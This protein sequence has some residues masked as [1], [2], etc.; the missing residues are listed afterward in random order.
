M[1]TRA[2]G[3]TFGSFRVFLLVGGGALSGCTP[4]PIL[5]SPD[6]SGPETVDTVEELPDASQ[7]PVDHESEPGDLIIDPGAPYFSGAGFWASSSWWESTATGGY[8]GPSYLV[9]P[10]IEGS[11]P[12][13]YWWQEARPACRSV[14]AWWT[15]GSN[16]SIRATYL[17]VDE[18]GRELARRVVNQ[19]SGGGGWQPLFDVDVPAG[20]VRVLLSRWDEPGRYTVADA[21]RI[22]SC[23]GDPVEP[24]PEP[25]PEPDPEVEPWIDFVSPAAGAT[26]DN[27]VTFRMEGEGIA[28][29]RLSSDGWE[30]ASWD[31]EREGWEVTY[32][33]SETDRPR[34]IRAEA[35]SAT[36]ERVAR[37]ERTITPVGATSGLEDVP[38][39]YQYDNYYEPSATCGLT[40]TAMV[41][42]YWT[43]R[44]LVPD[45][46][47]ERYGKAQGQS[48]SGISALLGWY[49]LYTEWTTNGSRADL[50]YWLDEGHP[51]IVHGNWTGAGHIAVL[52]GYDDSDWIV[53]D[54]AGDWE[55]CYGCG[56]GEA[57]RYAR[58]GSWDSRLSWDGDIW[59]SVAGTRPL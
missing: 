12:A 29:I 9:A 1:V 53:H 32:S 41:L 11:D 34:N 46:L 27:P 7:V 15:D 3:G 35:F 21:I 2:L 51:V 52:I 38:Y 10:T 50:R 36:G 55:V 14:A 18:R 31:V 39:F 56:G 54:P 8:Y 13:E 22:R 26:V 23:G 58:G 40:S 19:T 57:V 4:G 24:E 47:Y 6:A 30:M 49:G 25:E 59:Y 17:V 16:R 43:G 45:D 20:E 37:V 5:V 42:E 33:F 28:S 44:G 48:P